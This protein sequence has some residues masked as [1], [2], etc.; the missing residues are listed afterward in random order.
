MIKKRLGLTV[1]IILLVFLL[2]S[3]VSAHELWIEVAEEA[4]G[5]ELKVEV[6]WGHIRDFLDRASHEDYQLFVR[7]PGGNVQELDLEGVGVIGR[8]YLVPQE[9]GEY[10]F[11]ALRNPG[12]FTPGDGVTTLSV[13]L[14]KSVYQFG[15]GATTA[16]EPVDVLLEIVP[17]TDLSTFKSGNIEGTVLLE[18]NPAEGAALSAYGPGD[19]ALEGS[20]DAGGNFE[21]N[22][23][24]PGTWLIKANVSQ[25]EEGTHGGDE[26][27][28]VSRT[29]TLVIDTEDSGTV[30]A[31]APGTEASGS[32]PI[33]MGM[34]FI[35][36]LLLG[37][38]GTFF[39]T[40][41]NA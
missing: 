7:F 2:S 16:E 24:V 23:D 27:G 19:R 18:G 37:A 21:L 36:G 31:A 26:Y 12:T 6:L 22:L 38:A 8:A 1:L 20:T 35:I 9:Q 33:M 40:K 11:W 39:V 32:S 30:P 3:S 34:I 28:R 15:E 5:N 29:T 14:A 13:Q 41:K 10:V 25:E 4:G 17:T